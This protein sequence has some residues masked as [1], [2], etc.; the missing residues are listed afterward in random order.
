M[1]VAM[2]MFL[3]GEPRWVPYAAPGTDG[4][5]VRILAQRV[6]VLNEQVAELRRRVADLEAESHQP[7]APPMAGSAAVQNGIW[8]T[9]VARRS[10]TR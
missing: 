9:A 7:A 5:R 2:N 8:P 4:A 3:G 1:E 6:E 10:A